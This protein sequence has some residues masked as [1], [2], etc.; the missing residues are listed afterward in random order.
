MPDYAALPLPAGVPAAPT[1]AVVLAVTE[2][3]AVD[4][5]GTV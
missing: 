2:G 1:A 5:G 4:A 3:P